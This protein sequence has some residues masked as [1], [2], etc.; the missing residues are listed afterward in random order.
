MKRKGRSRIKKAVVRL[1]FDNYI[2]VKGFDY[3]ESFGIIA[4]E[5]LVYIKTDGELRLI[6]SKEY[7]IPL[8]KIVE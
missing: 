2:E 6:V 7:F 5:V 1:Y 4:G 3:E 8:E